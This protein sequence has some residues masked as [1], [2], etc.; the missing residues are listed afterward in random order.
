MIDTFALMV[1]V[2]CLVFY[3][4]AQLRQR[5]D[6]AYTSLAALIG[7]LT[8]GIM[9][10]VIILASGL[11]LVVVLQRIFNF[12]IRPFNRLLAHSST[13]AVTFGI[14]KLPGGTLPLSTGQ[15]QAEVLIAVIAV[16]MGIM[17]GQVMESWLEKTFKLEPLQV[18]FGLVYVLMA[19]FLPP[20]AYNGGLAVFLIVLAVLAL[21]AFTFGA[22][23]R[24][25]HRL[26]RRT[27]EVSLL[28]NIGQFTSNN[29][30]LDELLWHIYQHVNRL[31][32]VSIFYI[33]IYDEEQE[34]L[35]FRLVVADGQRISW[36]PRKMGGGSTEYVIRKKSPLHINATERMKTP[37]LQKYT[38]TAPYMD[39][40]GV[41]LLVE[42]QVVGVMSALSTE[43]EDAFG[44][45]E[46]TIL[47][48]VANQVALA[49]RNAMLYTRQSEMIGKL[50]IINQS[51]YQV[52][53]GGNRDDALT[54]AC[55]T[56]AA[57][58]GTP[59]VALFLAQDDQ[60]HLKTSDSLTEAH[61]HWLDAHP[62]PVAT[63]LRVVADV[64]DTDD[65]N[66]K[67]IS[68]LGQFRALAEVPLR[69][70]HEMRGL[71]AVYHDAPHYFQRR[72]L[73]LLETLANQ[74]TA[75]LENVDLFEVMENYTFEMSQ[76]AQLSRV[77]T[78]SLNLNQVVA[79][80]AAMLQ[81]MTNVNRVAIY[82][83]ENDQQQARLLASVN[84]HQ[85]QPSAIG[86]Y[87]PLLP[88]FAQLATMTSPQSCAYQHTDVHLSNAL[89]QQMAEHAEQTVVLVP[90]LVDN[91][92]LGAVLLGSLETRNFATREWHFIDLAANQIAA[93]INNIRLHEKTSADLNRRLNEV[94]VIEDIA[95]QVS[96]SLDFNQ[97]INH[98]LEAAMKAV[99]ADLVSLGLLTEADQF[100]V[101]EL[102]QVDGEPQ[103]R[104]MSQALNAGLLGK[105]ARTGEV[106]IV[107]DN[108]NA[109]NYVS[110]YV[111]EYRSSLGVP[112]LKKEQVIGVLNVESHE[113]NAFNADQI[114][115]LT[116]LAGH[117]VVSI[118]NA[119]FL[120]QRQQEIEMLRR[121]RELSLWLVT[122]DDIRSVGQAIL[123][124]AVD[125]LEGQDAVLY[126]YERP[127]DRL[128]LLAE[129]WADDQNGP[130]M[131]TFSEA[132]AYESAHRGELHMVA[133]VQQHP[134]YIEGAAF[135]FESMLAVPLKRGP[136]VQ[137][138]LCITFANQRQLTAHDRDT[139]D[140]LAGQAVGHLENVS[141][142][143]RIRAGRDQMRAILDS[144]Q[145]GMI[146]LDRD[147]RLI[148]TNPAAHRLLDIDLQPCRG[149]LITD[150]LQN[151]A[152]NSYSQ[153]A[154]KN[155][156][157]TLRDAPDAT[158]HFNFDR[159][160][161]GQVVYVEETGLPV[162]DADQK[163]TGRLLVLRD[164]TGIKQLEAQREDLTDM[165]V[166]DLR[167]PLGSIQNALDLALITLDDETA[168]EE[169]TLLLN[170][171]RTNTV[172]LLRLVETLLDI[173]K[174]QSPDMALAL[175][176]VSVVQ[177]VETAYMALASALQQAQINVEFDIP[178][179]LPLVLADE[180]KI[181]RVLVNLLD[182][183]L[184]YT[185]TGGEICIQVKIITPD[186]WMA[187]IINDS[188]PGIPPD[189][190]DE[191]FERFNRVPGQVPKR[192]HKGNG[193]GLNFSKQA[194][195]KHGG[196]IHVAADGKLPG[197]CF[198]FTLPIAK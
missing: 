197:A 185:P 79:D 56:A 48:T 52:L 75:M 41:P 126:A 7:L 29:L 54:A 53:F 49:L 171:S 32:E 191:I 163:I 181:E 198:V 120:E 44:S 67:S 106:V 11:G 107:P 124:T 112:L 51:V 72:E 192:G 38:P 23:D 140:L 111:D 176:P 28:S 127:S 89:G 136:Q 31:I 58:A 61:R 133:A 70:D 173:A 164:V 33:A 2:A 180:E 45:E 68:E 160:V 179:N 117:A 63:A 104:Y 93:Q 166:H 141:L 19:V 155:L 148:E 156:V 81:M 123:E 39:Y 22:T 131:Y 59:K 170:N 119:R 64:A 55:Q 24:A 4:L 135:N 15:H 154:L 118:E 85:Q 125:L 105:V 147:G 157:T 144:T 36:A 172:R 98:V 42:G 13:L 91:V 165:V 161:D 95:Q 30:E 35:E 184:R 80:V 90:L 139:L 174:M 152:E 94:A 128:N 159:V 101:I 116:S 25:Q 143:E 9:P 194:I 196:T 130:A 134:A 122:V 88:E 151:H 108:R 129:Q 100:W 102:R 6:V 92:V 14:I 26:R 1:V 43:S 188:G 5:P 10:A 193:L 40:L 57:V 27:Q 121:L 62:S 60:L 84:S 177:L 142:Q 74:I 77:S 3:V 189:Q 182:N 87:E 65:L 34:S 37:E 99:D 175:Q 132:V 138:V 115:F 168:L 8:V 47:Q 78:S 110:D 18:V 113:A 186:Q 153:P 137:Y 50:S 71:L 12:P 86:Q 114:G 190:R 146:L 169:N 149:R 83:L 46:I 145:D 150:V 162:H 183:A 17:V 73:D 66:L 187:V 178:T 195:E 20:I 109:P 96:S 167:G 69:S 103:R 158:T 16:L 97:I 21:Q 82:T 76:L